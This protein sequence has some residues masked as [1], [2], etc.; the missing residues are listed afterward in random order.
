MIRIAGFLIDASVSENHSRNSDVTSYPVEESGDITDNIRNLPIEITIDG[1]VSDSPLND[2]AL[3]RSDGALPSEDALALFEKIY[4]D[5]EP[6]TIISSLMPY[7]NMAMKTL[8]IPKDSRTGKAL[9]FS[10]VFK[11]IELIT[12]NRT[13]IIVASP[14]A[15]P[16]VDL[17]SKTELGEDTPTPK[18]TEQGATILHSLFN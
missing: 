14:R 15:K 17:G 8:T 4:A 13:T 7:T 10:V 11:Q 6:V 2:V 3:E 9:R 18:K 12:N 5:R 1:I 16:K